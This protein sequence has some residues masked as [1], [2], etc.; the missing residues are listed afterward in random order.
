[1]R[2]SRRY[3][4]LPAI[5]VNIRDFVYDDMQFGHVQAEFARGTAGMTLNQF[6]A[7]HA[8]FVAKGSGSWLVRE[9]GPECRLEFVVESGD[10]L[11]FMEAMQLGSLVAGRT[12]PQPAD[13]KRLEMLR[14]FDPKMR[15]A[16]SRMWTEIKVR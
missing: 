16:L 8:A 7:Q 3:A 11:G 15:R 2:C 5:R 4:E 12:R 10:V 14:D 1:M 9:R 6:T 13:L